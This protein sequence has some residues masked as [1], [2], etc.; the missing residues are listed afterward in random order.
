MV[1]GNIAAASDGEK[2]TLKG[3]LTLLPACKLTGSVKKKVNKSQAGSK[4]TLQRRD[5][6]GRNYGQLGVRH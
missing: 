6:S 2:I 4:E 5:L 1:I 3:V